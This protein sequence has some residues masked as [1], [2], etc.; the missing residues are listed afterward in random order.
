MAVSGQQTLTGAPAAAHTQTNRLFMLGAIAALI[1]L[2]TF[3]LLF[4]LDQYPAPWYDE[5]SHLHVAKNYALYGVY[6]DSSSE[7][8]RPFGPAIGVGPTVMLPVSAVFSIFGVSIPAARVVIVVYSAL[9]L[10]ALYGIAS[11][12]LDWRYALVTVLLVLLAP[13]LKFVYYSRTVVGEV[14][15]LFF[16]VAALALWLKAGRLSL[17]RVVIVGVLFGLSCITKNQ[18]ALFILP[19]LFVCWIADLVWYRQRHWTHFII[20]GVLAGLIFAGWLYIVIVRLGQGDSF[21]ENLATLRTASEGAFVVLTSD[22]INRVA[23]L[24]S[25]SGLYAALFIAALLYGL[26][27]SLPRTREG[28]QVGTVMVM[29][30]VSSALFAVSLGWDRYGFAPMTLSALFVAHLLR[31]LLRDWQWRAMLEKP[32]ARVVGALVMSWAVVMIAFPLVNEVQS[33]RQQGSGDAYA[34]A[35]WLN[36]NVPPDVIIETWEQE[37]AVLTDHNYHYPPQITL[38]H[39]VAETWEGGPPVSQFYDFRDYV[40]PAYVVFGPFQY[41]TGLY[42]PERMT[43]Y[44]LA[45]TIG[46]YEIY[47]K[48]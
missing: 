13:T 18:Y 10:L 24:I 2:A 39:S 26:F 4:R 42:L 19:G 31:D 38:A 47:K 35:D 23:R 9:T 7:G 36:A 45:A 33:V 22:S 17:V 37:L 6:A 46:T 30:L 44:E 8:Y 12:F 5:G 43:D 40:D 21:A 14:P 25:D 15:G 34:V 29:L 28:Q 1:L 20:P 27:L 48:R 11:T 41:Y 16:L 32:A 3:L